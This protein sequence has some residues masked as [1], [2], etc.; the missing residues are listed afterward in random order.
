MMKHAI[1]ALLL[2][3]GV[4]SAASCAPLCTSSADGSEGDITDAE[5]FRRKLATSP[6]AAEQLFSGETGAADPV[7]RRTAFRT[8]LKGEKAESVLEKA[9]TDPDPV[10]R[11]RA[12]YEL[13]ARKGNES[14]P[15]LKQAVNDKDPLVAKM[16]LDCAK[17]L[18]DSGRSAEVLTLMAKKSP[19]PEIRKEALRI[20][21]FPYYRETKLLRDDPTHDQEVIVVKEVP[22][23]LDGWSFR[24]DPLADAHHK[25]WMAPGFDDSKWRKLKIGIWES[26][27]YNGYDGIAWYR[28]RFTMPPQGEAAGAE[29]CFGAVDESAWVWLNGK[30]VG[31]HDI[32]V[33]GWNKPFELDI[34]NEVKWDGENILVVRVEDTATA[35]GIWK[36]VVIHC[37]K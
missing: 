15:F 26:Q 7:L 35:G 14:V 6:E 33:V 17:G 32:G 5:A 2:A 36:P 11:A 24:A 19:V 21:D 34:T 29:I 23:P 9:L 1:F 28:I 16:V 12:V 31:Q 18:S 27:G 22:L 10:I 8:L 13:F 25:G 20:T 4:L 30:Y 3:S 37:V